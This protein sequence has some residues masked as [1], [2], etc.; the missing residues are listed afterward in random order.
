MA[1]PTLRAD[2]ILTLSLDCSCFQCV[3]SVL[4][5]ESIP[6]WPMCS[7]SKSQNSEYPRTTW[8]NGEIQHRDDDTLWTHPQIIW[9]LKLNIF[10]SVKSTIEFCIRW[11]QINRPF[12]N[13]L[14]I[15]SSRTEASSRCFTYQILEQH[16][17]THRQFFLIL[18]SQKRV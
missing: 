11:V 8:H 9:H 14:D 16:S 12:N 15:C 7:N 18:L 13:S 4:H 3:Y 17:F 2:R 6:G 5:Q 10:T 1:D